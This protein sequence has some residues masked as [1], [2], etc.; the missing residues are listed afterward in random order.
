V[1]IE[2]YWIVNLAE[3]QLEVYRCPAPMVNRPFGFGYKQIN[4]YT[5][6]DSISPLAHPESSINVVDFLP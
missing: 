2:D 1:G 5:D 3:R 6:G 4:Y